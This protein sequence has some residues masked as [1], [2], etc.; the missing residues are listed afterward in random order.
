MFF[1]TPGNLEGWWSEVVNYR[2]CAIPFLHQLFSVC[3]VFFLR[4]DYFSINGSTSQGVLVKVQVQYSLWATMRMVQWMFADRYVDIYQLLYFY[5]QNL[6]YSI[7]WR[8]N[9]NCLDCIWN[10]V[11]KQKL[12]EL[13]LFIVPALLSSLPWEKWDNWQVITPYFVFPL[14]RILL[15][16]SEIYRILDNKI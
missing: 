2:K 5:F 14:N 1:Q 9:L 11:W 13:A 7:F 8:E 12:T 15:S 3:S 4:V 16:I 6:L 10:S